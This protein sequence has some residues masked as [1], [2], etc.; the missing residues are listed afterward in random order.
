[1]KLYRAV[2]IR[3]DR[4]ER[5]KLE[6]EGPGAWLRESET[7]CSSRAIVELRDE[8]ALRPD[9]FS[10]PHQRGRWEPIARDSW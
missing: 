6:E 9:C 10:T 3:D 1:M 5:L 8:G 7:K 2:G 4:D